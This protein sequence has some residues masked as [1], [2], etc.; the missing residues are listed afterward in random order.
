MMN[1]D[2]IVYQISN[3]LR[4]VRALIKTSHCVWCD[5]TYDVLNVINKQ[6]ERETQKGGTIVWR[7]WNSDYRTFVCAMRIDVM[8]YINTENNA[9]G[10]HG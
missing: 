6:R 8:S 3:I 2:L 7:V 10:M 1:D 4:Y 5:G 9:G